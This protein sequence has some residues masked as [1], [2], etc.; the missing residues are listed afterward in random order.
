MLSRSD[1]ETL[2]RFIAA[3][4]DDGIPNLDRLWA[5]RAAALIKDLEELERRRDELTRE[6]DVDPEAG[7][8]Q[9]GETWVS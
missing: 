1:L 9:E 4:R 5:G 6:A 7:G 8:G 2:R 3:H